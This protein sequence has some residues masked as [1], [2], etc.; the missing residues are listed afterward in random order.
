[1]LFKHVWPWEE[2]PVSQKTYQS[3]SAIVIMSNVDKTML[4][5]HENKIK[6]IFN[7]IPLNT[8]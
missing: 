1:M 8:V 5:A 6:E 2:L 4:L 3:A 7:Q